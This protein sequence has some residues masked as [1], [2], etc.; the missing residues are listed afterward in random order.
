MQPDVMV[1][2]CKTHNY[3]MKKLLLLTA[4]IAGAAGAYAQSALEAYQ[5]SQP[6][7]YGTARFMSMGGAFGALGGDMT[8]LSFNPAG[9]GVYRSSEIG[10]TVN[11]DFQNSSMQFGQYTN[12]DNRT[13]FFMN[14]AGYIGA[15]RLN[16]S[17]MPNFNWGFTYNRRSNF[18]RRYA[19][20]AS[21]I[22]NS[23]SNYIAG[24]CN[25]NQ[26]TVG[27]VSTTESFNPYY[28]NDGGYAA[29]WISILGY[30]SWL[31]SPSG[32]GS[33]TAWNGLY[34]TGTSGDAIVQVSEE[35]GIDE[36]NIAF[37]G[38]FGNIV[39]WGMDFG[40]TDLEF[41][42]HSLYSESLTDAYVGG[43]S[44]VV[45]S[46]ANWDMYSYYH[47]GGTG[48]NYKLGVI[49]KPIQELRLG[50]AFHT[51]TWYNLT[52]YYYADVNF[53]YPQTTI[54]SG[55]AQTGDGYDGV[56]D[57]K[58]RTPWRFIASAAGVIADRMIVSLDVDWMGMQYMNLKSP[59]Y[60]SGV[61]NNPA[62]DPYYYANQD[63]KD[64]Y[65][66]SVTFRAGLEYRLT[67]SVSL[68]AGYAHV[69]EPVKE[70]AKNNEMTIYTSSTNLSP[71][72]SFDN[73]ADYVTAGMGYR[74]KHFYCDAAYVYRHK[75]AEWHAFTPDPQYPSNSG[76]QGQLTNNDH[77]IV[78]S[79]G[80]RF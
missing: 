70:A 65:K 53:D 25:D 52:E 60:N 55:M 26:L 11:L 37:G 72:Y 15:A 3:T 7:L 62:S 66:T 18:N 9:I 67:D 47:V 29:P 21:S 16:N 48:F 56:N 69:S 17:I 2:G 63:I 13:T 59:Y 30:D 6:D 24:V 61:F 23:M 41:T 50:L 31:V 22:P 49:V 12:K 32:Q 79:M 1:S 42:R 46:D 43:G 73:T 36:Y 68:R 39:Y 33:D 4:A 45:R 34:G 51:P 10:A 28:P 71:S 40:I 27:N 58:L 57:V 38:N 5:L 8:T 64:Y 78:L 77:S 74:Y 35:G 19:G 75:S 76:L 80:F 54:R 44:D 14:N 20:Y